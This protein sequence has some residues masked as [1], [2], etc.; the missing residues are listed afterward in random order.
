MKIKNFIMAAAMVL[1]PAA[2]GFAQSTS[3][4]TPIT[5]ND[6]DVAAVTKENNLKLNSAYQE[7]LAQYEHVGNEIN[8]V[9]EQID[10]ETASKRGYPKKRPCR[11]RLD[12]LMSTSNCFSISLTTRRCSLIWTRER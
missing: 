9:A 12:S 6:S 8:D 5:S 1:V 2:S 10:E 7:W 11:R 3:T 4:Y